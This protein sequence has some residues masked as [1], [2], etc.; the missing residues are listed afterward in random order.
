LA[1]EDRTKV[2]PQRAGSSEESRDPE[3]PVEFGLRL[4]E[5]TPEVSRRL[6]IERREGLLVAQVE[7]GSFAD[8]VGLLRGDILTDINRQPV[9]SLSEYRQLV[10]QLKPGQDVV[11]IV[12]RRQDET[13]MLTVPLPG[14]VPQPE[15]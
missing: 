6:G 8:D 11:F 2:F 7:P 14:V 3:G 10:G 5:L 12:L 13:R 9:R 4:E 1:V 15:K